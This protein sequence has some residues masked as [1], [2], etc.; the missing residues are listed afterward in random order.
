MK[1]NQ[2][3][4]AERWEDNKERCQEVM[5]TTIA[6]LTWRTDNEARDLCVEM[7]EKGIMDFE[8]VASGMK[9]NGKVDFENPFI[10]RVSEFFTEKGF[11][12]TEARQI[13]G[14][15]CEFSASTMLLEG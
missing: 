3:K 4:P 1:S 8:G 14:A 10:K 15:I 13:V 2:K 12:K 6:D 9:P 7:A 11:K 5:S